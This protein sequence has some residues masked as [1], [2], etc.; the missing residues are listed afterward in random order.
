MAFEIATLVQPDFDYDEMIGNRVA[1]EYERAG[2]SKPG[3]DGPV[4]DDG[5]MKARTVEIVSRAIVTSKDD[6][7][8][9]ALTNGELYAAVFPDG[10]GAKPNTAEALDEFEKDVMLALHRKVWGL[11]TP[12]PKG[13][14]QKQLGDTRMVLCRGPV[15]RRNDYLQ[16]VY[17]TA[18]PTLIM[19]YSLSPQ[20]DKWVRQADEL[21]KHAEMITDRQ[22]ELA[23]RVAAALSAGVSRARSAATLPA[24][25]L[26]ATAGNGRKPVELDQD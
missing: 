5:K 19:G 23:T 17:V 4:P 16:G 9:K 26:P 21:R 1:E 3:P 13:H 12:T 14:I 7:A 11:T 22:P 10:P 20:I 8:K 25:Q 24:A 2:Y 18:E 6:R 15:L